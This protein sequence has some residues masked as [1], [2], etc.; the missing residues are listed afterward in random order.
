M[1]ASHEFLKGRGAQINPTNPFLK[2]ELDNAAQ[3]GIDE[4]LTMRIETEIRLEHAKKIINKVPSPDIP[5]DF[6]INPYQGCEHGCAYCY[7]RNTHHYWGYSAGVDFERKIIVKKN[8]AELLA[9]EFEKKSWNPAPIMFSGNTDCYQPLERKLGITRKCLE[10]FKLYRNP[11]GIITKNHLVL[12]DLDILEVLAQ[13]NLVHVFVSITT[14]NPKLR[15]AMEP[16]TST[17]SKR[18]E[19]IEACARKNIPVGVMIGPIIPGLNNHELPEIMETAAQ[20]GAGSIG[21]STVRLNGA[22]GEIFENWI[23]IHFPERAEKVLNQIKS[24]HGGTLNDS[25]FGRRMRGEGK[26]AESISHLY[27]LLKERYFAGRSLP[28]Y[29]LTAFRKPGD[30]QLSLF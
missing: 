23:R 15:S 2:Q 9:A 4:P 21:Y 16:R 29:N 10:V 30:S 5:L 12:R 28:A 14:I 1:E 17:I 7:A 22:V 20:R 13:E 25:E 18:W 26:L 8:A 19:V 6:S 11:V 24:M 27:K 3:E